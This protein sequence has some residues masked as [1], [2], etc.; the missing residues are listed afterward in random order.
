MKDGEK[1]LDELGALKPREVYFRTHNLLSSGPGAPALKW[2]STNACSEDEQGRPVYDWSILDLIFDTYLERDVRPYAQIGFMPQA[3]S[4]KPEPCRHEW[5]PGFPYEEVY[6]GW[7]YPPNDYKKW[8]ELVY[9]W[10]LHC[11]ER[12]GKEEVEQWYWETWNEPNIPYWQG[13]PEEFHKLH[14]FAIDAV[15]RALPTARVGGPDVAGHGGDFMKAFLEHVLRGKNYATGETG[16]PLDFV[17]FHAKGSPKHVDGH[18]R[19]G[20]SA[21]LSTI[22]R[23]FEIIASYPELKDAQL[24]KASELTTLENGPGEVSIDDGEATL[25]FTLPRQGVSLIAVEWKQ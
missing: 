25:T 22:D 2:G 9:Q 14:D 5:R 18:V 12:Y 6:T 4:T 21:Q 13:T 20:I 19:M 7:A 16:T 15:R 10:A 3:L 11:V 24:Q 23:G 1:L 8:A 17:S